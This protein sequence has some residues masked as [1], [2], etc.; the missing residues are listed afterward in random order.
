MKQNKISVIVPIYN[1]EKYLKKCLDSIINQ[2][3]KN[4]EIILIDDKSTDN[5]LKIAKEYGKNNSNVKVLSNSKNSGLSFTRNRG[6]EESTG[7]YI[8]FIDSDD[9]I[10][11][12]Y[13]SSLIA[14]ASKA[15]VVVCDIN[16]IYPNNKMERKKCGETKTKK[17]DF[18]NN[19][20]AASACNKIFK[21]TLIGDMR[22]E[23]GK[24]NEDLAFVLPL[25]IKSKKVVYNNE[26]YYNYYQR[27]TSIQNKKISKKRFDIFTA[28]DLT[29]NRIQDVEEYENYKDAIIYNQIIVFLMYVLE[30]EENFKERY[31]YLKLFHKLAKKYKINKNIYFKEFLNNS[32][33]LYKIYYGLLISLNCYGLILLDNCLIA[34]YKKYKSRDLKRTKNDVTLQDIIEEAK[35]Q[36]NKSNDKKISVVVPNYNYSKYLYQRIYSI[37]TQNYKI[38][39][40]IILDDCSTDNSREIIDEI[41]NECKDYINIKK[42]YNKKNSGRAFIQWENGFTKATGDYVW[43]AEADDYCT[44][45]FLNHL[46]NNIKEDTIISYSDTAFIDSDGNLILKSI[47]PEID[48]MKTGHWN[49]TYNNSGLDEF[50]NYTF[51]NCT[52]ANVSSAI[53]KKSDYTKEFSLAKQYHQAGDWIFYAQLMHKGSISYYNKPLNFYRVHGNNISSV[54]KKDAHYKEIESIH[55]KYDEMYKLNSKQQE[56]IEKRNNFL[57]KVWDLPKE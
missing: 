40:L 28:V 50:N 44:S 39:E 27:G 7:D 17:L 20:L 42:I 45:D 25:I 14:S 13:Y 24:I 19:G 16:I 54:T 11:T 3:Y 35:K 29:L 33:K 56:E 57:K 47:V 38:Y 12:N 43:I 34:I 36:S 30:K 53:F 37:L 46:V 9:Y 5:S 52:I 21:K 4:I 23:V 2:D 26:V 22:F 51:L 10:P 8:S 18:I 48:V 1:V 55:N 49:K 15:D 32:R 31:K 6:I 41:V